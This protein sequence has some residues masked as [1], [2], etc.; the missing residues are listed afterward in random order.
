MVARTGL[1]AAST[2]LVSDPPR[3]SLEKLLEQD[4]EP[5]AISAQVNS[6]TD[7]E[8]KQFGLKAYTMNLMSLFGER[9]EPA[10]IRATAR[11]ATIS[12]MLGGWEYHH[13]YLP[14]LTSKPDALRLENMPIDLIEQALDRG[15]GAIVMTFHLGHM[16]YLPSDIAHAGIGVLLPL[17]GDAFADY[18]TA[19]QANPDA[20]L[21][22][23]L[24]F[25]N[26]EVAAGS[27]ALART[28][29]KGGCILSAIDGNTGID[30]T[31]GDQQ[32][33][34]VQ[35]HGVTA[36]VKVGLFTLAARFG[37]PII[38][39]AAHESGAQRVCSVGPV[40]DPGSRLKGERK[41]AFVAAS[42]QTAYSFFGEILEQHADE[43]CGGDLFHQW[44]V[45]GHAPQIELS[46]I[47]P[48]L[49][50]ILKAGGR[51]AINTRRIV[52][53]HSDDDLVWSDARSG[54]CFSL[55]AAM[56]NVVMRLA[57]PGVGVDRVWLNS[58]PEAERDQAWRLLCALAS[59]QA[60]VE[61]AS[62]PTDSEHRREV[63]ASV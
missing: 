12:K 31:S 19:R 20:S 52:P 61:I 8:L 23:N 48:A 30:G 57:D 38:V 44:R 22:N 21:W 39:A 33:V 40:I 37:T 7:E 56:A 18:T 36:Q 34:K 28:L 10:R 51:L 58:Q 62:D 41:D 43:W 15:R 3:R 35:I 26:V 32:R 13:H 54:G 5:V 45:P 24:R 27:I 60:V 6:A 17:A 9:W 14:S 1:A 16:R 55:P 59:R 25:E 4:G 29:A 47:E 46:E 42:A 63:V 53:L 50:R 49:E 11:A 2:K